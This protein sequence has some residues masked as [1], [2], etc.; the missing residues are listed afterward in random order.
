[1]HNVYPIFNV[2]VFLIIGCALQGQTALMD[3]EVKKSDSV[4]TR[5]KVLSDQLL[6]LDTTNAS[7]ELGRIYDDLGNAYKEIEN[8]KKSEF[9]FRKAIA[10]WNNLPN[11]S[12]QFLNK[13]RYDLSLLYKSHGLEEK[14]T[15]ALLDI[16]NDIRRDDFACD[17]YIDLAK[18]IGKGG[19]TYS[20]LNYLN[21]A[22]A[23][24]E[25]DKST[26]CEIKIRTMVIMVYAWKNNNEVDELKDR[27]ELDIVMSNLAI[28]EQKIEA[29]G[30]DEVY[31]IKSYNNASV[32][33]D[34]I[35]LKLSLSNYIKVREYYRDKGD[36]YNE[37][38][39]LS[40][41]ALA[42]YRLDMNT[43]AVKC[44]DEIIDRSEDAEQIATTYI[45]WAYYKNDSKV[46]RVPLI[47]KGI[48][49]LL[50]RSR[51]NG[52]QFEMPSIYEITESGT[53][54]DMIIYLIDLSG[55]YFEAF[56]EAKGNQY[57]YKSRATLYLADEL[58]SFI[59]NKSLNEAS[60]LL[61]IQSG[62][63]TY[64]L[65]VKICYLL[66]DVDGAF[67]FMEKN[68][69]LLL[70][71]NIE[72]FQTKL[73]LDIPQSVLEREY[74]LSSELLSLQKKING[75]KGEVDAQEFK[76]KF[77]EH[78]S[79]L[80]S[81][82]NHY[83]EYINDEKQDEIS[84]LMYVNE[85]YISDQSCFVEY[86]LGDAD[87]YGIFHS[88]S[89]NIFFKIE[90]IDVLQKELSQFKYFLSQPLLSK[91]EIEDFRSIGK[92]IFQKLFPFDNAIELLRNKKITIV[93][94]QYLQNI[95]FE[96]FPVLGNSNLS[97]DYLIHVCEISYL[98][99]FSLF[100]Q[101][102]QKENRAIKKVLG[103]APYQYNFDNL[104]NLNEG[105]SFMKYLS[106]IDSS[107]LLTGSEATK[108]NF[109]NEADKFELIHISTH[110]GIDSITQEPWLAFRENKLRLN[111]LL[112]IENNA[113]LVVL[114]ACKTNEGKR[115]SGEGIINLS[116]GFFYN[117]T[118]SVLSSLWNVNERSG[119]ML[120][121]L[122]YDRIK[123][124]NSKSKA[125][126]MAKIEYLGRHR[127]EKILPYYWAVHILNGS[128]DPIK[129]T[130]VKNHRSKFSPFIISLG[131]I[132]LFLLAWFF[133]RNKAN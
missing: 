91:K 117:G 11:A 19:D 103:V 94:D 125:L 131:A 35:D 114:D 102:A 33:I 54:M 80:D 69:A 82:K 116:R 68:K 38:E 16:I 39:A 76:M 90:S 18:K 97:D 15:N 106:R 130:S 122:F 66:N 31:L 83:P 36:T 96:A 63:D 52:E 118:K 1:M 95:P 17:A 62:V 59:R 115:I 43:E 73:E 64:N 119:S 32:T 45:N 44:Y 81:I 126:Q 77:E 49:I 37:L 132:F 93:P 70:Q 28:M 74:K 21:I 107:Q 61:W 27:E 47:E 128:T 56:E 75:G 6:E 121:K 111:E 4:S 129:I 42:Y 14:H 60:K 22:L 84:T 86:I 7:T 50:N 71:D 24:A 110:G 87:G 100:E 85:N 40:N 98:Q 5:I 30:L 88:H 65:G 78:T 57:L 53:E 104:S 41:V 48:D 105:K 8:I 46:D 29:S 9:Y 123:E 109:L 120:M 2:L 101:I 113:E 67:Y 58:V 26:A 99:S 72:T 92:S 51:S 34:L 23:N 25:K 133:Y 124:N 89:E 108:R 3:D 10:N 13:S 20:A 12:F 112:G 55:I 127:S 79:L